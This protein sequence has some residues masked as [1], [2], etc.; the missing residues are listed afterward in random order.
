MAA[1]QPL[2][3]Y[4]RRNV[5]NLRS[6]PCLLIS[7]SPPPDSSTKAVA[8]IKLQRQQDE[9]RARAFVERNAQHLALEFNLRTVPCHISSAY[10]TMASVN[11][12]V[13]LAKR[14]GLKGRGGGGAESGQGLIIGLGSGA[15]MDLAKAVADTLFGDISPCERD[16]RADP[17][18]STSL[19]LAPCTLSGLWAATSN[20]SVSLL[21]TKEEMLLP[22]LPAPW[23]IAAPAKRIGTVVTMDP[24]IFMTTPPL[25]VPFQPA[26][27]LDY[28]CAP[29][30]AHVAAAA[31]AI[32][33]DI[34]RSL[35]SVTSVGTE[36]NVDLHDLVKVE[37]KEVAS[38]FTSVLK[39]ATYEATNV[40]GDKDD[41][42]AKLAQR[43]LLDAI[44]R[45]SLVIELSS[46]ITNMPLTTAGTLPQKLAN[47]LLPTH[48]P[49][50]HLI[51]FLA[52]LL[53]PVCAT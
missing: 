25:Y 29:T 37:M 26:K 48:F 33:L 22:Y 20:S 10:P 39:L 8:D 12:S 31:L 17:D 43:H 44:P 1:L 21:D 45:I 24:S 34:A 23:R 53:F 5:D 2:R 4:I 41:N 9:P 28:S 52:D 40:G 6:S 46:L 27:R 13:S 42:N 14:A 30:M 19:V 36:N 50:C 49:Q 7:S 32:V 35:D 11:E 38:L 51:T 18:G 47:S 15:A 3:D 16:N